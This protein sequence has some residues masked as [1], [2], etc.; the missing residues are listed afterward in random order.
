MHGELGGENTSYPL[1]VISG[2]IEY[3]YVIRSDSLAANDVCHSVADVVLFDGSST[4]LED[5]KR[6]RENIDVHTCT[7]IESQAS[8]YL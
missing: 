1:S 5:E 8:V 2:C 3:R 7:H 6:M 4:S